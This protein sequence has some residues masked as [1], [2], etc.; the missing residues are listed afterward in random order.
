MTNLTR[1]QVE[2]LLKEAEESFPHGACLTC[3]CFLG[4]VAQLHVDSGPDSREVLK[5]YKVD[6]N[7][8]HGCLGCDPCPPGDLYAT[9][10]CQ[11]QA[12]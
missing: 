12:G 6:R 2:T 5:Q 7:S 1:A 9:Y 11:K 10:Q 4:Y 3:E 8:I